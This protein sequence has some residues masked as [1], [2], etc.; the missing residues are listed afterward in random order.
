MAV[1]W[2]VARAAVLLSAVAAAAA[3][4]V[5]LALDPIATVAAPLRRL[6]PAALAD[7][8]VSFDRAL[9]ALCGVALVACVLWLA[10]TTTVAVLAHVAA[11]LAP[12]SRSALVLDRA[13]QQGCPRTLRRLV[14]LALG[15]ALTGA[16]GVGAASANSAPTPPR[17][18]SEKPPATEAP[19]APVGL[20]LLDGVALPDRVTGADSGAEASRGAAPRPAPFDVP[21]EAAPRAG[22][23]ASP[24]ASPSAPESPDRR[25]VAS[26]S[27][28]PTPT[29]H[30]RHAPVEVRPGD[31]LWLIAER[32]LPAGA[33]NGHI[34][35]AWHRLHAANR[36]AIG[37]DPDLVLPGTRL[38]VPPLP[39]AAPAAVLRGDR[40]D[41]AP[42]SRSAPRVGATPDPGS[43]PTPDP[44]DPPSPAPSIDLL[45][46][47]S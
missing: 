27:P 16:T 19:P 39:G 11:D 20:P 12:A 7:G 32:L 41:P 4:T 38:H 21:G 1:A 2:S 25:R 30:P 47:L 28:T 5:G 33:G 46:D 23:S 24:G 14:A 10:A 31:S 40:P 17:H 8:V 26:G 34:T 6:G 9:V 13:S 18:A 3:G 36:A 45:E 15:V 22:P 42:P 29:G 37:P 44:A 35:V 43:T